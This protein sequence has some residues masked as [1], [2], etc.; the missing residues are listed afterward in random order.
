MLQNKKVG[1]D[2]DPNIFSCNY[3]D[4]TNRT[5]IVN[6]YK[7]VVMKEIYM[8][9]LEHLNEDF[10]DDLFYDALGALDCI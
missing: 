3:L 2:Y 10:D 8:H 7:V 9:L 1:C 5:A 6:V 4:Q